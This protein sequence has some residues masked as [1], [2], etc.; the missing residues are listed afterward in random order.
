VQ[1][2]QVAQLLSTKLAS[3]PYATSVVSYILIFNML[4]VPCQPYRHLFVFCL[5]TLANVG[6]PCVTRCHA[7][8]E[9]FQPMGLGW[10]TA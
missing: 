9:R 1:A 6:V 7:H 5:L 8:Q 2:T 3:I 10:M 4:S